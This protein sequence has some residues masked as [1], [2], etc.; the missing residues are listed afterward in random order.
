MV[1]PD[2]WTIIQRLKEMSYRVMKRHEGNL[3]A[4]YQMKEATLKKLHA[5]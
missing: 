5:I 4:Y 2:E 1:S 3:N